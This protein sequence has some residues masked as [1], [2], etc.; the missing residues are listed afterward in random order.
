M[1]SSQCSLFNNV[2][3][4]KS[5]ILLYDEEVRMTYR[6]KSEAVSGKFFTHQNLR[7]RTNFQGTLPYL[8]LAE[9]IYYIKMGEKGPLVEQ[10]GC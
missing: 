8:N 6:L 4:K 5:K 3:E 7:R 2:T 10:N 1:Y 9:K